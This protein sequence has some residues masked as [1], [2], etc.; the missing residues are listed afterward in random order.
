MPDVVSPADIGIEE[1]A[2][3]IGAEIMPSIAYWTG[4]DLIPS[5]NF[6][7]W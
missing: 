3:G 7:M 1:M 5:E 4:K 6:E 2:A